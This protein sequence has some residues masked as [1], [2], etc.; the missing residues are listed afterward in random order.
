MAEGDNRINLDKLAIL[1]VDMQPSFLES[2]GAIERKRLIRAHEEILIACVRRDYPVAVLEYAGRGRTHKNLRSLI[3]Q[4]PRFEFFKK[5]FDNGFTNPHLLE[6]F[7]EWGT[8]EIC[9]TGINASFCVKSTASS[10]ISY[11]KRIITARELVENQASEY[12]R[13]KEDLPWFKEFGLYFP[14]YQSLK[15]RI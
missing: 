2:I 3:H 4:I 13:F 9:I 14:D 5:V 1:I 12:Q 11:G 15:D 6:K 10:A 7:N 8:S